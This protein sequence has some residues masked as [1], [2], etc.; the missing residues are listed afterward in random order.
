MDSRIRQL[1]VIIFIQ[2]WIAA[3]QNQDSAAMQALKEAWQNTTP[4]S[5]NEGSDPCGWEGI[6]C[7]NFRVTQICLPS[8]QLI[9]GLP[10]DIGQLPE[11]QILAL[12]YNPGLTGS[13]TPA[14]G[15]LSKLTNLQFWDYEPKGLNYDLGFRVLVGCSF[16]GPIPDTIGNLQQLVILSL[17]ANRFTG[18]IPPSIGNLKHLYWLDLTENQL[19][20]SIP[21]SKGTTPGLDMLTHAKHFHLG[22]N[23]LSGSIPPQL[24]NSNMSL[25]HLLFESNKF[26]GSIPST[27]GLV[28]S[29]EVV[30]LDRNSLTGNVPSNINNLTNVTEMFLS[31]N[32]LTGHVPNLTG[33]NLLNY[34]KMKNTNLRGELPAAL[35][36]IPQL[37]NVLVNNPI[38]TE[39]GVTDKF[40]S[41]LTNTTTSYSTLPNNCIP[42]SCGAGL[43]SSPNC[44]CAFPYV[45]SFIF[46][47]PSFSSL[48]NTTIYNS[49][50]DSLMAFC[51]K[52]QFPVDS[53]SLM[54]PYRN[55]DDYL[56]LSLEVFPSGELSFNRTGIL[57]LGFV[58][59][60]QTFKPSKNFNTYIFIAQNY[61]NFLAEVANGY[62][63]PEYY[64]TQQLTEKS[65]VYSFG[66]VMLELITARNP[67]EKGKYIVREVKEAMNKSKP[68]YG[69]HEVLD[70][71]IGLSNQLKG[72]ERFVDVSIRC[73]ELTGNQL[74][75][76]ISH[77]DMGP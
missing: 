55:L 25:I 4:P 3:A 49:L 73:V 53:V 39:S 63:D 51:R 32:Q 10:G 47:A 23:Q 45:G 70:P 67:I 18:S 75:S 16:S 68:L 33:M 77:Y 28:T 41:L 37:Q 76:N 6:I 21:V 52:S 56:V 69:L 2:I 44:K 27:L 64:M 36:E 71:T 31:Y 5:W 17:N 59:S 19:T 43:V 54:N 62:M 12:S 65:D 48:G 72:L 9:G 57:W 26:T 61:D 58:L 66:V 14:I 35:F 20:G 1:V 46:K 24:F 29:L 38:C 50:R 60:N 42:A 30:R 22:D 13:L 15:K 8:M 34:L 40:C 74:Q 11:L 7:T